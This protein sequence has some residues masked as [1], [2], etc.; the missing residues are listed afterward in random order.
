M[1][2][3]KIKDLQEVLY[4][5]IITT[6][7]NII[8]KCKFTHPVFNTTPDSLLCTYTFSIFAFRQYSASVD[9]T[10]SPRYKSLDDNFHPVRR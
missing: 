3:R 7:G 10:N 2:G 4:T 1:K 9:G 8:E 6:V 5:F